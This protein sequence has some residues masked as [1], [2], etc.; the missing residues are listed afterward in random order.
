VSRD[1]N[2]YNPIQEALFMLEKFKKTFYTILNLAGLKIDDRN[3]KHF[4]LPLPKDIFYR[5]IDFLPPD[6]KIHLMLVNKSFYKITMESHALYEKNLI[7]NAKRIKAIINSL[8]PYFSEHCKEIGVDLKKLQP[9]NDIVSNS[10]EA[11]KITQSNTN[12]VK[13]LMEEL[14]GK[15]SDYLLA[16]EDCLDYL[17]KIINNFHLYKTGKEVENL[18]GEEEDRDTKEIYF[19]TP[20]IAQVKAVHLLKYLEVN[21]Y[22]LSE[23]YEEIINTLVIGR[24]SIYNTVNLLY[25]NLPEID[26]AQGVRELFELAYNI[27]CNKAT[28]FRIKCRTDKEHCLASLLYMFQQEY[29]LSFNCLNQLYDYSRLR[30]FTVNFIFQS[31]LSFLDPVNDQKEKMVKKI[32]SL[33]EPLCKNN[34]KGSIEGRIL[35]EAISK[36][37]GPLVEMF[38]KSGIS[39]NNL[40][41]GISPLYLACEKGDLKIVEMLLKYGANPNQRNKI[42][43]SHQKNNSTS[44]YYYIVDEYDRATAL[45]AAVRSNKL[46]IIKLLVNNEPEKA[47]LEVLDSNKR[48]PLYNAV[49]EDREEIALYLIA[50]GSKNFDLIDY[51]RTSLIHC[52]VRHGHKKVV[53]ELIKGKVNLFA[54]RYMPEESVLHLAANHP[55]ILKLL[56]DEGCVKIIDSLSLG[57]TPL[58]CAIEKGNLRAC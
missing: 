56:L 57:T 41:G 9:P 22:D 26:N 23:S 11:K 32:N 10:I 43:F 55:D 38:L 7:L 51:N 8:F 3:K 33:I 18:I 54:I 24:D 28:L 16:K 12:K 13:K 21:N 14:L 30:L 15:L 47:D 35:H 36:G 2:K 20:L 40:T 50:H 49:R 5:I 52:A 1:K 42:E 31:Y 44:G 29:S 19:Y 17:E 4:F 46:E 58:M 45:H 48:S 34:Y 37:A 39:I 25:K 53:E 27:I 6:E